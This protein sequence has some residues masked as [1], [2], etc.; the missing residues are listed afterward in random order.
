MDSLFLLPTQALPPPTSEAFPLTLSFL[1]SA[2][3]PT[4]AGCG[5]SLQSSKPVPS[6]DLS[7]HLGP[8]AQICS[9]YT[10]KLWSFS[11]YREP[12]L[13]GLVTGRS[14]RLHW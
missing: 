2:A 14:F 4:E 9:N 8:S 3:Q 5:L 12:S 7:A 10:A 1:C 11:S 13:W 6:Q